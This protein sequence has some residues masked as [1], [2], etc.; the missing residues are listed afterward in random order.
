MSPSGIRRFRCS[1][2]PTISA[3]TLKLV[4]DDLTRQRSPS[5]AF[6]PSDSMMSPA[7]LVT[8]PTLSIDAEC[9]TWV[10]RISTR[11]PTEE[12]MRVQVSWRGSC[13]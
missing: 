9:R 1:R 11:G 10:R 13:A 6:G 5:P 3:L 12:V 8:V 4:R 2:N 7:T